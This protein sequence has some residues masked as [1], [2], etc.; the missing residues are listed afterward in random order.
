MADKK[1]I[2]LTAATADLAAGD[3]VKKFAKKAVS[4]NT[5][6]AGDVLAEASQVA[7]AVKVAPEGLA[8]AFEGDAAFAIVEAGADLNAT[9]DAVLEAADRRTLVVLAADNG[10]FFYG[11][12]VKKKEEI[13]RAAAACDVV[14]TICY[15]ADLEVPAE[16][17]GAVLYQVLKDPNLKMN[18]INKLKEALSRMEA[19]LQR[20]NR[21]PWDKHDCA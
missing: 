10:L 9:M 12:G 17:T 14:P 18:E 13:A 15:V 19:A 3:A 2:L 4:L 8:A 20:D 5:Y 11:L 21:E 1:V 6:A 7:G 16:T